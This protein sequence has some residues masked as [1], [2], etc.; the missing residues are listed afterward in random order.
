MFY[1][2]PTIFGTH[3][4]H[5]AWSYCESSFT[6]PLQVFSLIT[7]SAV[8]GGTLGADVPHGFPHTKNMTKYSEYNRNTNISKLKHT[9]KER[10]D[11]LYLCEVFL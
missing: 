10:Q 8:R 5:G 6:F 1:S 9:P 2:K 3:V 11:G 4:S 7:V